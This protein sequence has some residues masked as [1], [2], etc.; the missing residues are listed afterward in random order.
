MLSGKMK[1]DVYRW[2]E[3]EAAT[4]AEMEREKPISRILT[5][6]M[7]VFTSAHKIHNRVGLIYHHT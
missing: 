2:A 3:T 5:I 7:F 6:Q 1:E 4:A